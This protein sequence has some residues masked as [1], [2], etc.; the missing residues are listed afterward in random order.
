L[1][2]DGDRA[3]TDPGFWLDAVIQMDKSI[4]DDIGKSKFA[5]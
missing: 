4:Q 5:Q 2:R 1:S 3:S